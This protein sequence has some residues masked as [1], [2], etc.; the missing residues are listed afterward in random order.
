MQNSLTNVALAKKP[1]DMKTV[2]S[3]PLKKTINYVETSV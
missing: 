1:P 2:I 3:K